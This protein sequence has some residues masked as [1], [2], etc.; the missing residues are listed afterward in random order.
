MPI[1]PGLPVSRRVMNLA[2]FVTQSARRFPHRPA[3]IWGGRRWDWLEFDAR[4]SALA[5]VLAEH[6]VGYG[7]RVLVQ[8]KNSNLMLESMYACFRIGAVWVPTNFRLLPSDVA[9]IATASG[10]RALLCGG[11]FPGHAA[12]VRQAVPDLAFVARMGP[13]ELDAPDLDTLIA[14]RLGV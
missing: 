4:V 11:E 14:E 8:S 2:R 3:L 12:A 10:A 1:G 7:D 6:G 13:G 5:A 9:Y